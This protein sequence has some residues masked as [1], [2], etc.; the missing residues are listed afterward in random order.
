MGIGKRLLISGCW[1]CL[2]FYHSYDRVQFTMLEINSLKW[3]CISDA[4]EFST[5]KTHFNWIKT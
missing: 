4:N 1:N 5:I 2:K 3:I